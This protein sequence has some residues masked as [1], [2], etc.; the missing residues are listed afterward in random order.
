MKEI[1]SSLNKFYFANF[2]AV[3]SILFSIIFMFYVQFKVE[4]LQDI[5]AQ[6]RVNISD[7]EDQIRLLEVEWVYLT[8]PERLRQI[9]TRFL[10]NNGYALASQIKGEEEIERFYNANYNI[11]D[12][13]G[14]DELSQEQKI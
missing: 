14:N 7:Y 6:N 1:W 3:L 8:R 11:E 13:Q 12:V 2:M 4:K 5:I 9:S 10:K